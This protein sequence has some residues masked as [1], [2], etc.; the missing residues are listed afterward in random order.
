MEAPSVNVLATIFLPHT[1]LNDSNHFSA[2]RRSET[3]CL[4]PQSNRPPAD[5]YAAFLAGTHDF[6]AIIKILSGTSAPCI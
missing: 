3:S 4:C 6:S 1:I 2:M 5:S